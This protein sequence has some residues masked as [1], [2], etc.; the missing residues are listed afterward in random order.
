MA[1]KFAKILARI[2][3][4]VWILIWLTYMSS[5]LSSPAEAFTRL[6][7]ITIP[8]LLITF[9]LIWLSRDRGD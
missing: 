8:V 9:V 1:K 5:E 4:T 6:G 3:L 2:I 7:I